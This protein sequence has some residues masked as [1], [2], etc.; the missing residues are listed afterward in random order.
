[1]AL[2]PTFHRRKDGQVN[3]T[4]VVR[5]PTWLGDTLMALPVLRVIQRSCERTVLWGPSP[6]LE[7]L[8]ASGVPSNYLPY[9]R[10]CG[11]AGV[12]DAIHAVADM[13]LFRADAILLLPNS[14]ESALLATI[15]GIP[16]RVGYP[17][18]GRE[19]LLTD[20]VSEIR[21]KHMVHEADRFARL[22]EH[23]GFVAAG[24]ND[25]RLRISEPDNHVTEIL[26]PSNTYVGIF[27]GSANDPAKRWPVASFAHLIDLLHQEW[28]IHPVLFGSNADRSVN[29][30]IIAACKT[31]VANLSGISLTNLASAL[32]KCRMI[33]SN[34]TGGAHLSAA[35]GRPTAVVYGPTDPARSCPRGDHVL[36]LS[37]QR[38]CQPCGYDECP[39]DHACMVKLS[40]D[41]VLTKLEGFWRAAL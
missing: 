23:A 30:A 34:D 38:F 13:R 14:F 9:R 2:T 37:T 39:L 4:W 5:L 22:A 19:L 8:A 7:L 6:Y 29:D 28:G 26:L 21:P 15:A 36:E 35:L 40:P 41:R 11:V 31:E 20:V 10:R 17:T 16:R 33:V 18:D 25:D 32:M 12:S 24:P 3:C 1:M 27:A